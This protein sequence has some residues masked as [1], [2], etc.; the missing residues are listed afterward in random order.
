MRHARST[1]TLLLD[2]IALVPLDY[3]H[4]NDEP[5][6]IE[7]SPADYHVSVRARR[8][9]VKAVVVSGSDLRKRVPNGALFRV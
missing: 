6:E 9:K 4:R 3:K 7:R 5:D 2:V 1:L 8:A